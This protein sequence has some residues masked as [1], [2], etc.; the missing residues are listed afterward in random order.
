MVIHDLHVESVFALPDKAYPP[1]VIDPYAELTCAVSSERSN[2]FPGGIFRSSNRSA[3]SRI[4]SFRC[5]ARSIAW[6]RPTAT[7]WNNSSVSRQRK[8]WIMPWAILIIMTWKPLYHF[9]E[10]PSS[11]VE[12]PSK[13]LAR[14]AD[15]PSRSGTGCRTIPAFLRHRRCGRSGGESAAWRSHNRSASRRCWDSAKGSP[16]SSTRPGLAGAD[17]GPS[18]SSAAAGFRSSAAAGN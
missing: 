15:K 2:R 1:L 9:P 8:P 13:L 12:D 17:R 3:A 5:A 11:L 10:H 14:L 16:A 4:A 18:S 7:S 6:N